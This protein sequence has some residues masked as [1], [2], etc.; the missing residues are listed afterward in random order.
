MIYIYIQVCVCISLSVSL[1]L[2]RYMYLYLS[3]S[4]YIYTHKNIIHTS[5]QHEEIRGNHLSNTT[6]LTHVFFKSGEQ[7]SELN[8][9]HQTGSAAENKRGRIRQEAL[10]KQC[11]PILFYSIIFL[12]ILFYVYKSLSLSLHIYMYIYVY[13]YLH[14]YAST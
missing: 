3:L 13:L 10:D 11:H 7:R 6:R 4:I 1:S 12:S 5:T 2:S 9:P 8:Q 14:K